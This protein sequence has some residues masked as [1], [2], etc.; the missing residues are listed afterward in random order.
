MYIV[1]IGSK[2]NGP[3]ISTLCEPSPN[4]EGNWPEGPPYRVFS[5]NFWWGGLK[6]FGP[7]RSPTGTKSDGGGDLRKKSDWSQNCPLKGVLHLWALFLKTL[8]IFSKNK[9]TSD[10]VSY[11]SGQKCSKE[12][13]NYSFQKRP[14]LWSYSE[15]C[16]KINIFHVLS[17]KSI[18]TWVSEIP[19]Q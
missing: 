19:V 5:L 1:Y 13:K 18:T 15:K 7:H 12:L 4:F 9:A 16:A 8:C 17:H 3:L 6:I 10:K 2:Y 11:G 14:L